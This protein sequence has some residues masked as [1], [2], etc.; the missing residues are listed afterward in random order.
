M[1]L[2]RNAFAACRALEVGSTLLEVRE[3]WG[4]LAISVDGVSD[5]NRAA[6]D[7]ILEAARVSS[8]RVCEVSGRAGVLM[9]SPTGWF[10]TLDPS[11]APDGWSVVLDGAQAP[12]EQTRTLLKI[13][14]R[15]H[16]EM[17]S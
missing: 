10:R 1:H 4:E 16:R 15:L 9:V 7:D 2:V 3:R 11:T 8:R 5:E 13:I 17:R 14:D 6:V 12:D